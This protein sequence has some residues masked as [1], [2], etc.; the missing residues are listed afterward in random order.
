ME[1]NNKKVMECFVAFINSADPILGQEVISPEAVFFAPISPE[2][3]R[4][5]EGYMM[6]LGMMR[7]GFPDVQ[8]QV[9]ELI[10]EEN[11]VAVRFTLTGTHNG[12]FMGIPPTG[13]PVKITCINFYHFKDGK[14]VQEEGLPDLFNLINQI[15]GK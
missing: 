9:D 15:Q 12:D 5:L 3:L 14:I 11:T 8:W 13:K 7:S 1:A 2:P 4:G 10:A 6:V